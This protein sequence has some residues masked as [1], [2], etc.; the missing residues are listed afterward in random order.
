[1]GKLKF[2]YKKGSKTGKGKIPV[3]R[4]LSKDHTLYPVYFNKYGLARPK[5]E[6]KKILEEIHKQKIEV[7]NEK[8]L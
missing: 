8:K 5:E 2:N 1:M 4:L 6:V 7:N 3:I